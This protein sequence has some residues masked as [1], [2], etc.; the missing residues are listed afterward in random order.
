MMTIIHQW[1]TKGN[2]SHQPIFKPISLSATGSEQRSEL[3]KM[4]IIE[5]EN[6]ENNDHTWI[7]DEDKDINDIDSTSMDNII[8]VSLSQFRI[9]KMMKTH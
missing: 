4:G 9:L 5:S 7:Q 8:C 2:Q 6:T 1:N 3:E